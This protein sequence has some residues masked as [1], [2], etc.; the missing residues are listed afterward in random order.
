MNMS[1]FDVLKF[2]CSKVQMELCK[3]LR[4]F[5]VSSLVSSHPWDCVNLCEEMYFVKLAPN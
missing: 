3:L 5:E 2:E 4:V 1:C